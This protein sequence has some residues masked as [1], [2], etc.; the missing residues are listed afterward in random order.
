VS[1]PSRSLQPTDAHLERVRQHYGT[2]DSGP[3]PAGR[4]YRSILA[5]YYRLM[6]PPE[7]S[8]LE[9]GCGQGRLLARLPNQDVTGVDLSQ[10]QVGLA[11]GRVP[12]GT[13][14]VQSGERLSIDRTFD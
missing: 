9:V 11:R 2:A 7:A 8:V 3:G 5:H 1:D 10:K 12:R 6:I 4:S 13:F 14:H